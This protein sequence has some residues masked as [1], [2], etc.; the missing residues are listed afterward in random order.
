MNK[1]RT[2][3]EFAFHLVKLA[4]ALLFGPMI[5]SEIA[6]SQF[7]ESMLFL[8]S[9]S[10]RDR[11]CLNVSVDVLPRLVIHNNDVLRISSRPDATLKTKSV[12]TTKNSKY[13][14]K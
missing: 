10:E 13:P 12:V 2:H 9:V 4:D 14:N 6:T 1:M 7:D 8:R 11:I 3:L 5:Q